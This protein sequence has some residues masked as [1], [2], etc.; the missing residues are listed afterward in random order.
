MATELILWHFIEDNRLWRGLL[1]CLTT[2]WVTPN[3]GK[4][5]TIHL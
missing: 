3:G 5:W 4:A 1:A 2:Y